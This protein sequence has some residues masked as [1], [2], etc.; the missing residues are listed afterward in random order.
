MLFKNSGVITQE[1]YEFYNTHR[2]TNAYVCAYCAHVHIHGCVPIHCVTGLIMYPTEY[3]CVNSN[4]K[5]SKKLNLNYSDNFD[6][7]RR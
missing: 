5:L 6:V 1:V 2:L 3:Q 4:E 7:E